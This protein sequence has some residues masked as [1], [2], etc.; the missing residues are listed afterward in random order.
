MSRITNI[1]RPRVI[2]LA[3][4]IATPPLLSCC[5]GGI[6]FDDPTRD[7]TQRIVT[8]SSTAGNAQA[9]NTVIQTPGPWPAAGYNTI[10]PADGPA[11]VKAIGR[12][13]NHEDVPAGGAAPA[14]AGFGPVPAPAPQ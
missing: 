14:A 13:E 10:V 3:A 9:S 1:G 7:Y 12:Y 5:S 8:V 6:A 4:M 2:A 11:M